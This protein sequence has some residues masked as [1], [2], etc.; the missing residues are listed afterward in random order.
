MNIGA[1]LVGLALLFLAVPFVAGPFLP[2]KRLG[3]AQ[4]ARRKAGK[5]EHEN[6]ERRDVFAALRDLE[7]DHQTGKVTDGDFKQLQAQLMVEAA[8]IIQEE[9]AAKTTAVAQDQELEVRL[10][11]RRESQGA[12]GFCS[13]CG[14]RLQVEDKF[15]PKCGK[16]LCE[17]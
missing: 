11:A 1:V 13:H 9:Q 8:T 14:R 7:F 6:N 12:A 17:R 10:R 4:Q 16:P 5:P 3:T 15:C 2:K